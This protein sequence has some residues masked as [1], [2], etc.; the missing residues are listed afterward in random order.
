MF[1][2]F[3]QNGSLEFMIN[4]YDSLSTDP[5]YPRIIEEF[6]FQEDWFQEWFS[7]LSIE[8]LPTES[9]EIFPCSNEFIT[10]LFTFHPNANYRKLFF[11]FLSSYLS[12]N[13]SKQ[14][15][16]F[17]SFCFELF[18]KKIESESSGLKEIKREKLIYIEINLFL[19]IASLFAKFPIESSVEGMRKCLSILQ[20]CNPLRTFFQ[21]TSLFTFLTSISNCYYQDQECSLMLAKLHH[22]LIINSLYFD[23]I[24]INI[25]ENSIFRFYLELCKK[26]GKVDQFVRNIFLMEFEFLN[27]ENINLIVDLFKGLSKEIVG[28][29]LQERYSIDQGK[30]IKIESN[31][32]DQLFLSFAPIKNIPSLRF[33]LKL[34]NILIERF[35]EFRNRSFEQDYKMFSNEVS[36]Q[37]TKVSLSDDLLKNILIHSKDSKANYE[38]LIQFFTVDNIGLLLDYFIPIYFVVLQ[39]TSIQVA[40][41]CANLIYH[42]LKSTIAITSFPSFIWDIE[43]LRSSI[44]QLLIENYFN[45]SFIPLELFHIDDLIQY[46]LSLI[47]NIHKLKTTNS[48][49]MPYFIEKY[50]TNLKILS[51]LLKFPSNEQF[52]ELI[53]KYNENNFNSWALVIEKYWKRFGCEHESIFKFIQDSLSRLNDLT[54]E[55]FL[56]VVRLQLKLKNGIVDEKMRDRLNFLCSSSPV[57]C[58]YWEALV[59]LYPTSDTL[60]KLLRNN[61]P[62]VVFVH[63]CENCTREQF[64]SLLQDIKLLLWSFPKFHFFSSS[65]SILL[66]DYLTGII[67]MPYKGK[68]IRMLMNLFLLKICSSFNLS[69][70][71]NS[72]VVLGQLL[73]SLVRSSTAYKEYFSKQTQ[74]FL[75]VLTNRL[76]C[77]NQVLTFDQSIKIFVSLLPTCLKSFPALYFDSLEH[78]IVARMMEIENRGEKDLSI[79]KCHQSTFN[80]SFDIAPLKGLIDGLRQ[81]KEIIALFIPKIIVVVVKL[82]IQSANIQGQN[83]KNFNCILSQLSDCLGEVENEFILKSLL[84]DDDSR[85]Y[86]RDIL[87][88]EIII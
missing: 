87:K 53:D 45:S 9:K 10:N 22:N 84:L 41:Y 25:K 80:Y 54:P 72:V 28:N 6:L 24:L 37:Q 30:R 50:F 71:N 13:S 20:S 19:K 32:I 60:V 1:I 86:Y 75:L 61:V 11:T 35:E 64:V 77:T 33:D 78:L 63:L 23:S 21:W 55:Q 51:F 58:C 39:G 48:K 57:D 56:L 12:E 76:N 79:V 73:V 38:L 66:L 42:L 43:I 8:H 85:S 59:I 40:D 83:K 18:A 7:L 69:I 34:H 62:Q 15:C 2:D 27:Q 17:L 52:E 81:Y 49:Y 16:S 74:S 88:R 44:K 70:I 46:D 14:F 68:F 82:L 5:L 65:T 26:I 67:D 29:V 4:S 36:K 31:L 47:E 3:I